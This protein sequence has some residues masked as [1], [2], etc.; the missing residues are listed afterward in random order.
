MKRWMVNR[1]LAL[2]HGPYNIHRQA[3]ELI[4][5][6]DLAT[7]A[8]LLSFSRTQSRFV[9]GLL[10]GHNTL[11]RHLYVMGLMMM[12]AGGEGPSSPKAP[13][14][15]RQALC[16]PLKVISSLIHL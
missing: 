12:M 4:S 9:I 3:P 11:R 2:W 6:P 10:T 7:G 16:A 14:P 5:G 13:R 8:H 15:Y 1:L